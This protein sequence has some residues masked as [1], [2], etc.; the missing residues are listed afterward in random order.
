MGKITSRVWELVTNCEFLSEDKIK[1][2]LST[3]TLKGDGVRG[4]KGSISRWA[5]IKHDKDIYTNEKIL[6][7]KPELKG[8]PKTDHWHI[9]MQFT[10]NQ[11]LDRIADWFGVA[12]NFFE[13][14]RGQNA[15][16]EKCH[17]ITHEADNQQSLG[18]HLY[19]DNEV[20]SN[21]DFRATVDSYTKRKLELMNR[22]GKTSLSVR[23]QLRLDVLVNGVS[24][25]EIKKEYPLNYAD[26]LSKLKSLRFEYLCAQ[27]PAP[28][29]MNIYIDGQGRVGKDLMSVGIA[30]SWFPNLPDDE[31]FFIVGAKGVA[32]EGYD[33]QP[34][35]IWSDR[36]SASFIAEF[37]RENVF[38]GIFNTF[39]NQRS[40]QNVKYG[41]VPL[42]NTIN[43]VNG[44]ED[45]KTFLDGLAGE[46]T[47]RDNIRYK[48]EDKNQ[49][50]GRF[51]LIIPVRY[52]DFDIMINKGYAEDDISKFQEYYHYQ[53]IT[54]TMRKIAK[55]CNGREELAKKLESQLLN[56]VVSTGQQLLA[57]KLQSGQELSDD[58]ILDAFSDFGTAMSR[59]ESYNEY[60]TDFRQAFKL[61]NPKLDFSKAFSFDEWLKNGRHNAYDPVAKKFYRRKDK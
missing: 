21:F 50:Y 51:P 27:K 5:Y 45:Y 26:D 29:R 49:A 6:Q 46:Y 11:E 37:G 42:L 25:R 40:T 23:D 9:I 59:A 58:E 13:K 32:F 2:V 7:D 57:D 53:T 22:Y 33:G 43:I 19:S 4:G 55:M 36:R 31:C 15:F 24:L 41:S 47:S 14:G 18:K 20:Y 8:S 30:R 60:N 10:Y 48:A 52:D 12:P 39:P 34:V 44:V 3:Y 56:S 35:I 16:E 38:S 1:E 28:L 17:Y 61:A 54:G